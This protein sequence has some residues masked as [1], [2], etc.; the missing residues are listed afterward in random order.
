MVKQVFQPV[1]LIVAALVFT[2]CSKGPE[3]ADA[4]EPVAKEAALPP[5]PIAA[6]SA[7]FEMYKPARAWASDLFPLSLASGEI[8]GIKNEGGK[9]AQW[10]AV[11]VSPTRRE[12]RTL[13]YSVADSGTTIHK[14][15]FVGGSQPWSGPTP[16]SK[17]F[18]V[19]EFITNSD[20]AYR[21]AMTKAEP[22]VKKHPE[23]KLALFLANAS[24]Q[25]P[26]P[27][28][29]LL[30]GDTKSGYMAHVNATTG[31]LVSIK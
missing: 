22:W 21:V 20:E 10:T 4:K 27:L 25:H 11:F 24:A 9:A 1:I 15:V 30:W 3:K 14:G 2:G 31:T 13:V 7:F 6:R 17:P 26:G 29:Y 23:K 28:W 8:P 16:K 5:E 12:A 19:T 18:Q